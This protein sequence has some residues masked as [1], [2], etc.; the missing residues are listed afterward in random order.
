MFTLG[1]CCVPPTG[2]SHTEECG[3]G[4]MAAAFRRGEEEAAAAPTPCPRCNGRGYL[5]DDPCPDCPAVPG[6]YDTH[7]CQACE[8][9]GEEIEPR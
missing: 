2:M 5:T 6:T 1:Q 8:G 3:A 4:R 9:L 7:E